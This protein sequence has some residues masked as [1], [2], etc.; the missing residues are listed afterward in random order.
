MWGVKKLTASAGVNSNHPVVPVLAKQ[1]RGVL[2]DM[3]G[4]LSDSEALHWRAYRE[5]FLRLV[6]T[7]GAN[8]ISRDFYNQNMGGKTKASALASI[9]PGIGAAE[10]SRICQALEQVLFS[11]CSSFS[12]LGH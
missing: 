11:S 3:D 9:L 4:T 2:F 6:P 5:V 7:F 12:L 8:P 1:L 10:Q